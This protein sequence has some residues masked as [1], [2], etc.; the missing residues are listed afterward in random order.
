M[1]CRNA[2]VLVRSA[3]QFDA[4]AEAQT[5]LLTLSEL[6]MGESGVEWLEISYCGMSLW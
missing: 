1:V 2:R 6:V 3:P 4:T 5:Q